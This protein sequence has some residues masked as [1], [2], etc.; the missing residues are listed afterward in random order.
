MCR[1]AICF[2]FSDTNYLD[3]HIFGSQIQR[4]RSLDLQQMIQFLFDGCIGTDTLR[5]RQTNGMTG[6]SKDTL[7]I[8]SINPVPSPLIT[9]EKIV[10]AKLNQYQ[11]TVPS[12]VGHSYEWTIPTIGSIKG[13]HTNNAV[14]VTWN[15]SGSD[16]LKVRQTNTTT[17]CFKDTSIIVNVSEL[18]TPKI[19][20][21][22]K[23]LPKLFTINIHRQSNTRLS[24][25]NG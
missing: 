20:G 10:C 24:R 13:S 7:L 4:V 9:G 16:T 6:C 22:Q 25:S 3:I 5:V 12:I 17:G 19:T 23:Y 11:Y 14:T 8:V 2:I 1:H 18:P 21:E 15:I